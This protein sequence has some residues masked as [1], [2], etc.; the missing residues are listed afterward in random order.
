MSAEVLIEM[1][2]VDVPTGDGGEMVMRGVDWRVTRGEC[3]AVGGAPASGKT[4]LLATAASLNRPGGGALRYFGRE[5]DEATE[6]EQVD[7]RRRMGFVFGE[8]GRL[9]SHLT[10]AQNVALPLRYHAEE[11]D[12][13]ELGERVAG[14]L[15]RTQLSAHARTMPSRLSQRLSQRAGLARALA[16]P[17]EVLFLDNPLSGL[18][19]HDARWWTDYLRELRDEKVAET[20]RAQTGASTSALTIVATCDHFRPWLELATK[21]AVIDG[22]RLRLLGGRDGVLASTESSVRELL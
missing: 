13:D 17:T 6:D 16:V 4:S 10:V 2:G 19:P 9:L 18:G 12:D 22:D 7:W 5:L 20:G 11:M 3:W 8:G 21:F 15:A 1:A 14:L